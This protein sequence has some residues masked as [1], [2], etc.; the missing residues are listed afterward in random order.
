VKSGRAAADNPGQELAMSALLRLI[1]VVCSLILL[2]SF[3]MF[4]ADQARHGSKA[5]VAKIAAGDD[6]QGPA[7]QQP[8]KP[9]SQHS[10][11]RRAV[12]G[13]DQKLVSPFNGVV[14]N[15]DGWSRHIAL[16]ILGF[17]VFGVGIGF[18]ARYAATRGL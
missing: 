18:V 13:A 16:L 10:G 3:A 15:T 11:F 5:T 14:G 6:S 7:V 2:L 4:A 9:K 1:S 17:L 12:D 8:A